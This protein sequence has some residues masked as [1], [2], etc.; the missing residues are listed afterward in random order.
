MALLV[1]VA[2]VLLTIV[3]YRNHQ[4]SKAPFESQAQ[5]TSLLRVR[6]KS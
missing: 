2:M 1:V 6:G 3:Q 5:N 4:T